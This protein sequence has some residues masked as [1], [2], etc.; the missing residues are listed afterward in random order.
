MADSFEND[1]QE[2]I[3]AEEAPPAEAAFGGD[4][5]EEQPPPD[6]GDFGAAGFGEEADAGFFGGEQ[7]PASDDPFGEAPEVPA[8]EAD[9]DAAMP[10]GDDFGAQEHPPSELTTESFAMPAFQEE[11]N[12]KVAEMREAMR[13]RLREVDEREAECKAEAAKAAKSFLETHAKSREE[14]TQRRKK[15]NREEESLSGG[16]EPSGATYWER[17]VEYIDFSAP[18]KGV[19]MSRYKNVLFAAKAK[20]VPVQ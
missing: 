1:F 9:S 19:D 7:A 12:P 16:Q 17:I 6:E 5:F 3:P 11:E 15:N 13:L 20:N 10:L 14:A 4:D 18:T 8:A 2:G